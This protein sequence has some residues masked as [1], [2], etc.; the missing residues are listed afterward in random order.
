MIF[1]TDRVTGLTHINHENLKVPTAHLRLHA[2]T[3]GDYHLPLADAFS[4]EL[5]KVL[6]EKY[7]RPQVI[8]KERPAMQVLAKAS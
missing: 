3:V 8:V 4:F 7:A 1:D 5:F 6:R 2:K